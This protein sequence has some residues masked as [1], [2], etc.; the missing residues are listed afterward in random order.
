M[1]LAAQEVGLV[2]AV[3]DLFHSFLVV[4]VILGI[5]SDLL[6]DGFVAGQLLHDIA[7]QINVVAAG[8]AAPFIIV[9]SLTIYPSCQNT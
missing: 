5:Q 2:I 7:D 6:H 8:C 3:G 1:V 9:H 4:G